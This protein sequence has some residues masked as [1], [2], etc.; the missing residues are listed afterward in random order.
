M[1]LISF[2]ARVAPEGHIEPMG[3]ASAEA[4]MEPASQGSK[5]L[6]A[7]SHGAALPKGRKRKQSAASAAPKRK[8]AG[9]IAEPKAAHAGEAASAGEGLGASSSGLAPTAPDPAEHA[10]EVVSS[11]E[12]FVGDGFPGDIPSS[13]P[14]NGK[15][16][17]LQSLEKEVEMWKLKFME[18]HQASLPSTPVATCGDTGSTESKPGTAGDDDSF[19]KFWS[20]L[21][22][23]D[24]FM[25][26]T[27]NEVLFADIEKQ[28]STCF[29]VPDI[30]VQQDE[31]DGLGKALSAAVTNNTFDIR[32]SLGQRFNKAHPKGCELHTK[33]HQNKTWESKRLF[34]IEWAKDELKKIKV[35][36]SH[37][38]VSKTIDKNK[39]VYKPF[40][41]LVEGQGF[42][43]DPQGA[44]RRASRY[45]SKCLR[46]GPP[47][48]S[49]NSMT[50]TLEF[51]EV[52]RE[53]SEEFEEIWST[54]RVEFSEG[55][56]K[57]NAALNDGADGI[58]TGEEA[59]PKV[60]PK[61]SPRPKSKLTELLSHAKNVKIKYQTVTSQAAALS[62]T[63]NSGAKEWRFAANDDN[64]GELLELQKALQSKLS[65]SL[66][67]FLITE[68]KDLAKRFGDEYLTTLLR[69]F[70]DIEPDIDN[71]AKGHKKL[72]ARY[73]A[74]TV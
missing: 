59:K 24:D 18:A 15:L 46:L 34:R 31:N 13:Q 11:E 38:K 8:Q 70:L 52:K 19:E 5:V 21:S 53:H 57:N 29:K 51:L 47:F 39:G 64:H 9:P 32:G 7:D 10:V 44:I 74:G 33:Y 54:W 20:D 35:T 66:K 73:A 25:K 3:S 61:Q 17:N 2:F 55:D 72:M 4:S 28:L 68:T 6:D 22:K 49:F 71:L 56:K 48:C 42:S 23:G 58:V 26:G 40:A 62:E 16:A 1:S 63:I 14:R 45:T 67:T 50:D 30:N 27:N 60:N 65:S 43:F 69:E 12:G 41:C 36:K 37:G